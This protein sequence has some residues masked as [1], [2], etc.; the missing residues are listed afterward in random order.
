M[1]H[2]ARSLGKLVSLTQLHA[3][4]AHCPSAGHVVS[5]VVLTKP[6]TLPGWKSPSLETDAVSGAS[7]Q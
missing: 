6:L 7:G 5:L 2:G 1:G 3:Y 4:C